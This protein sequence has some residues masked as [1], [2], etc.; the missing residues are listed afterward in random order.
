MYSE[1]YN[2]TGKIDIYNQKTK[3]LIERKKHVVT[4]YEGYIFQLY[5]QYYCMLEMGYEIAALKIHSMDDNKTYTVDLPSED[6][7]MNEKF[8]KLINDIEDFSLEEYVQTNEKKCKTCIY[9]S[10]CDRS[11]IGETNA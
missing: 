8:E 6:I 10:L 3:E 5:A 1:K 4:V 9:E 11:L 7:N 2:L